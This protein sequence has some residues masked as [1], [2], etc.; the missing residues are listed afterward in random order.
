MAQ[1]ENAEKGGYRGR[2]YWSRR[3]PLP[4]GMG[5]GRYSKQ[6]THRYERRQ[7]RVVIRRELDDWHGTDPNEVLSV[8]ERIGE[9]TIVCRNQAEVDE[10]LG[11]G[12]NTV[13]E[14]DL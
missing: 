5:W 7:H 10:W 9:D 14:A 2:E 11:L 3:C 1:G 12:W 6:V 8:S 4:H 13:L